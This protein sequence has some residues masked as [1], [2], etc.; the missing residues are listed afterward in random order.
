MALPRMV[1]V[2]ECEEA[3][4]D[5]YL[6]VQRTLGDIAED[7]MIIVGVYELLA[8]KKVKKILHVDEHRDP[9]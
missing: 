2:K 6:D 9:K 1:Y 4:G 8:K 7:D 5:K 3:N